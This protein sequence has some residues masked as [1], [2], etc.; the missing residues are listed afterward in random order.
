MAV[1]MTYINISHFMKIRALQKCVLGD[2]RAILCLSK[3]CVS[4]LDP[5]KRVL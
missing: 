1:H 5:D 3:S 4:Y 2:L